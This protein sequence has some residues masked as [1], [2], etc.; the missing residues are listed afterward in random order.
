MRAVAIMFV[1]LGACSVPAGE[2]EA[3]VER[4]VAAF[5]TDVQPLLKAG[6]ASLDCHGTAGRPLRLYAEYGLRERVE[7]RTQPVSADELTANVAAFAGISV[8]VILG[9]PLHTSAGGMKHV[10]GDLW[11]SK[12]SPEYVCVAAWLNGTSAPS[13]CA[14][15][16][17]AAPY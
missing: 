13:A 15:A 11:S 16:V 4:D 3:I 1:V 8:D 10:G 2:P 6:C 14:A 9:K 5:A 17:D 7:L 12:D